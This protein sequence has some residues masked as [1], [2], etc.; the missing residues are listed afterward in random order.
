MIKA[1]DPWL[2]Q[3]NIA[4]PGFF[5]GTPP[6]STQPVELPF[7]RI[8]EEEATSSLL[9][10]EV[11][12][13]VVEVS[14]FEEDFKVFNQPLSLEPIDAN[15]SHL[16]PAQVSNIQEAPSIPNAM[17]LQ[18]KAKTSLLE[19]HVEGIV[20][21]VAI[22]T[23]PPTSLPT[24]TSQPDLANKKRKRDWKGK[25][26]AKEGEVIPSNEPKP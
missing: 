10:P 6:E 23:K 25:N 26:I 7:Q 22:Q 11:T 16:P 9:V 20:P 5:V 8:A 1:K 2:Q 15:F 4:I 17:V 13:K 24:Q 18:C 14:D 12:T 3:I 19:S 21:E